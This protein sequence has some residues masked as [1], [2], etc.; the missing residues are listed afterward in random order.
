[1]FGDS[2]CHIYALQLTA[3]EKFERDRNGLRASKDFMG[4]LMNKDLRLLRFE[5]LETT[6]EVLRA[7]KEAPIG[8][9]ER[10]AKLLGKEPSVISNHVGRIAKAFGV[11]FFE[12]GPDRR[13]SPAGI[14]ALDR[15]RL[16][17]AEFERLKSDCE[18]LATEM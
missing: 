9:Q 6:I 1:M 18:R 11:A 17:L 15:G 3:F 16:I 14:L 4:T 2:E 5:Y 8:A 13:L 10:V 12:A 7:A